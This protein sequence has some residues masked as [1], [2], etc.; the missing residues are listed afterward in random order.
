VVL[1][2]PAALAGRSYRTTLQV[3]HGCDGSPTTAIKVLIPAGFQGA[4]PMPKPGWTLT[5]TLARLDKPYISH[6]KTVT[7]DVAEITWSASSKES[8]LPDAHYDEFVLRGG[9]PATAGP[10]WFKVLQTCEKGSNA[11]VEVPASGTSTKGLKAP[12]VLLE[13]I[14]SSAVGHQ[15]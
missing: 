13:I 12:A 15:H 14:E 9:L 3:G 8:W 5:A 11:W 4:K 6:G 2:E 1:D 7:E 10:M